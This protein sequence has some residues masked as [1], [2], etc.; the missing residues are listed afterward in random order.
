M[1]NDIRGQHGGRRPG[2]GRKPSLKPLSLIRLLDPEIRVLL[3]ELTAHERKASGNPQ[4]S[5]EQVVADLIRATHHQLELEQQQLENINNQNA[6]DL[7]P[8]FPL[9]TSRITQVRRDVTS[10]TT[11]LRTKNAVGVRAGRQLLALLEELITLHAAQILPWAILEELD[12][13]HKDDAERD[14]AIAQLLQRPLVEYRQAQWERDLA[15]FAAQLAGGAI[16][17]QADQWALIN[18]AVDISSASMVTNERSADLWQRL[19]TH[20]IDPTPWLALTTPVTNASDK[21]V[22]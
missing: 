5:Q 18:L 3:V 7:L 15:A 21:A 6:A 9:D 16:R 2:A 20:K 22:D 14:Q 17:R 12:R 1:T 8:Q 10:L 13:S 4:L 11:R 19:I